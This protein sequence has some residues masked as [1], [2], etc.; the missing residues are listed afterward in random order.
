[1]QQRPCNPA[2]DHLDALVGKWETAATH[3]RSPDTVVRGRATVAWLEG[4]CFLIQRARTEHPDV[5]DSSAVIGCD[6]PDGACSMHSFDARDAARV[7][8][9][10]AEAGVWRFWR[11]WPGFSQ[12]YVPTISADGQTVPGS[13]ELSRDGVTWEPDLPIT[14][15][16]LSGQA[17]G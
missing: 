14:D 8:A 6:A 11:D 1:M 13:W 3:P 7:Y 2:L 5:P 4:G 16:R 10:G 12:R 15:R 17:A 9:V